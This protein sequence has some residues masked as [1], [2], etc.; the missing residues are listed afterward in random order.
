[1]LHCVGT[2][3]GR[4]DLLITAENLDCMKYYS[5]RYSWILIQFYA[6]CHAGNIRE[7]Y[8]INGSWGQVCPY[9]DAQLHLKA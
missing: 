5:N 6:S 9:T 7:I 3:M 4:H 2:M 8:L 1:M